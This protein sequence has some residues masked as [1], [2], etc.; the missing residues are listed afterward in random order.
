MP[1][2]MPWADPVTVPDDIRALQHDIDAY[3][4]EQ[5]LARRRHRRQRITSSRLWQR[6]SFPIGVLTGALA[7]AAVV[8]VL[9]AVDTAGHGGRRTAV[10]LANPSAATG[11]L[12]GLLPTS[13]VTT[14]D[15]QR[16]PAQ[17]LRP[18]LVLLLPSHCSCRDLLDALA[19]QAA[20][21]QV[22]LVVIGPGAPDAEI[23]ALPGQL[24]RGRVVAAYD[25]AGHLASTYA[26]KGV[27]AL[28]VGRDGVVTYIQRG[29]TART[30]LELPLQAAL[31]DGISGRS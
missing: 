11:S 23:T 24:H 2:E 5:R 12:G 14:S 21:V 25:D 30:R 28:I 6:W 4:R 20:E 9:L 15:G 1:E 22:Q 17:S 3:H 16:I 31:L 18:A 29:L 19:A 13:L 27:T 10:P 26:A 7:L 8:V